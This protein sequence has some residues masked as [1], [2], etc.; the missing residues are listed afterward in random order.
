[1][2][3]CPTCHREIGTDSLT[4]SKRVRGAQGTDAEGQPVPFWTGDPT[5]TARGLNG[6]IYEGVQH[7]RIPFLKEIQEVLNEQEAEAGLPQT[8]FSD[9]TNVTHISVHLI[10]EIREAIERLLDASGGTLEDYFKLDAGGNE[11]TQNPKIENI[12]GENPQIEWVDVSRSLTYLDK[13]GNQKSD[14]LLSDGFT[15]APSPTIPAGTHLRAIHIED[16]RHP[17]IVGVPALMIH[18]Q[19][20]LLFNSSLAGVRFKKTEEC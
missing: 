7:M 1:M 20:G 12:G 14:F 11:Q 3:L 5:L 9:L 6:V 2:A 13:D 4:P 18:S 8:E 17:I 15:T 10:T 19:N 16:M